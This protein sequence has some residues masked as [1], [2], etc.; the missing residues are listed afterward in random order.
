[1]VTASIVQLEP[2]VED[3]AKPAALPEHIPVELLLVV[4]EAEAQGPEEMVTMQHQ[5]LLAQAELESVLI[6]YLEEE[7][8]AAVEHRQETELGQVAV[9]E[10]LVP[11][12]VQ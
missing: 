4:E 7:E 10:A 5:Q 6:H 2:A 8:A 3:P 1:M 9:V 11:E 12:Q